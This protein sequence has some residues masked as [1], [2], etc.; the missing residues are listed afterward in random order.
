MYTHIMCCSMAA[1]GTAPS[2]PRPAA[3]APAVP[4]E[5]NMT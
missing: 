2:A 3:G 1:P 4:S 5:S